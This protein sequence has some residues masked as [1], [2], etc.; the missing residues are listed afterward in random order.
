MVYDS[1]QVNGSLAIV[2]FNRET[3]QHGNPRHLGG[4]RAT[5]QKLSEECVPEIQNWTLS[6]NQPLDVMIFLANGMERERDG[7]SPMTN[8]KQPKIGEV[9]STNVG[10][11][12]SILQHIG[13]IE[14]DDQEVF[15]DGLDQSHQ[16]NS[17]LRKTTHHHSPL[18]SY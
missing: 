13:L 9:E 10:H 3:H 14:E 11:P 15:V 5:R 12:T 2:P 8:F 4:K 1:S 7:I 17:C 18:V 16:P 6:S